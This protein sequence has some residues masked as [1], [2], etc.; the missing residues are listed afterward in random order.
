MDTAARIEAYKQFLRIKYSEDAKG[1]RALIV[2]LG[3]G[4][5]GE[6]VLITQHTFEGGNAAGQITLEPLAKLQ[7]AMDVLAEIDPDNMPDAPA[8]TQYAD[9]RYGILET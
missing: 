5:A 2:N 6:A 3:D 1:L 8:S 4:A 9:F 7:A